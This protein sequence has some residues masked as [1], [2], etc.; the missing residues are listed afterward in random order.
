MDSYTQSG[1]KETRNAILVSIMHTDDELA[2]QEYR[3]MALGS[4]ILA[5]CVGRVAYMVTLKMLEKYF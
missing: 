2:E 5:M 3:V 4:S 1:D